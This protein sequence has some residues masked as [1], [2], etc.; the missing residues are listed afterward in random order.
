MN[1]VAGLENPD[2]FLTEELTRARINVEQLPRP[3]R[4][5]PEVHAGVIGRLGQF[6]FRRAWY[7][8]VANGPVPIELARKLYADPVGVKDIRVDGHCGCPAPDDFGGNYFAA[9]GSRILV[10]P[11]GSEQRTIA[12]FPDL[13]KEERFVFVSSK[14][15]RREIA[16]SIII[17]CYH[18]DSEVG[19][20]I[21]ADAIHE[22]E[23]V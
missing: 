8:W 18:I 4:R 5:H 11:E 10:D 23:D 19:L 13:F 3:L 9:D 12:K 14:E 21:F 6:T 20:R 1:N 7:Y 15:E 2:P 17:D 16:K 22:L